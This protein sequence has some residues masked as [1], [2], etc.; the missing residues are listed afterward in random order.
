MWLSK[1]SSARFWLAHRPMARSLSDAASLPI[2]I[3][4]PTVGTF[5]VL[6]AVASRAGRRA[7]PELMLLARDGS[8]P[9]GRLCAICALGRMMATV[10]AARIALNRIARLPLIGAHG[11][12][13]RAAVPDY[14]WP[15]EGN[16]D[17]LVRLEFLDDPWWDASAIREHGPT[18]PSRRAK[19]QEA[20]RP[21]ARDRFG[22]PLHEQSNPPPSLFPDG[23]W[24]E[25]D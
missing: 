24:R 14:R 5:H 8:Q 20:P 13:V 2:G 3:A 6:A 23:W 7:I 9:L 12:V 17:P 4:T 1:S 15:Y 19:P 11:Y 10:P 18:R 25:Q 21:V 22:I 16:W